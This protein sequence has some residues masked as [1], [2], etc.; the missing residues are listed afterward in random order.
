MAQLLAERRRRSED[1]LFL[2]V[3]L[4]LL[5]RGHLLLDL[6]RLF[7][8]AAVVDKGQVHVLS[9]RLLWWWKTERERERGRRRGGGKGSEK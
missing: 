9:D 4:V 7:L 3:V 5:L 1:L 6:V 8:V 2:E